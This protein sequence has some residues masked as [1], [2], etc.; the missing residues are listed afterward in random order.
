LGTTTSVWLPPGL[1]DVARPHRCGDLLVHRVDLGL[2]LALGIARGLARVIRDAHAAQAR[3][4]LRAS[5]RGNECDSGGQRGRQQGM[6]EC[7]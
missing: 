3:Q 6:P 1:A 2:Q 4:G 7:R 5:R